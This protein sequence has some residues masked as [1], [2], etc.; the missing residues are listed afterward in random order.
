MERN[1]VFTFKNMAARFPEISGEEIQK[2]ADKAVKK[3]KVK[4]TK[5]WMNVWTLKEF[6]NRN[7]TENLSAPI[8]N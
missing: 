2:L 4:T 3:N 1:Y 7:I 8:I 5:M 6:L